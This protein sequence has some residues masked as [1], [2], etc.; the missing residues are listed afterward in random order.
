MN[1]IPEFRAFIST[2]R[3]LSRVALP[4]TALAFAALI[5]G[6]RGASDA[7]TGAT[8][9]TWA[10]TTNW[11]GGTVPGAGDTA[12]FNAASANTTV[13]L[14][15]GVTLSSLVFDTASA[16]AYTIGSGGAGNQTLT[17]GAAGNAI[18]MNS[19]VVN[20]QLLNANLAF[21]TNAITVNNSS[22]TNALTIAGSLTG[23][24]NF[25][26]SGVGTLV[27]TGT[28]APTG[29]LVLNAGRLNV[30]AGTTNFGG[31]FSNLA[32]TA[33]TT[34]IV[35]VSSGA[36]FGLTGNNGGNF[37]NAIG[38]SAVLYN[39]GTFNQSATTVNNAGIYLGNKAS[40]Y[41]YLQN[42][43][44][45]TTT[46]AGR[47][48]IARGEAAAGSV[49][50]LDI[51]GGTVS[52]NPVGNFT[53]VQ[54]LQINGDGNTHATSTSYAGV[55]VVNG[56]LTVGGNAAQTNINTGQNEYTSFNI[57]GTG[58]FTAGNSG[59]DS[60]IGLSVTNIATNTATLSISNGGT[61]ETSYIYNNNALGTGIISIDN[62]TIRS[63]FNNATG[64]IQGTNTKTYIQSGGVTFDTNGFA[65]IAQN[66][67]LAPSGNG[68]TSITLGGTATSYVG[69]PVVQISGGGGTGA[70][71]IANFDPTTG[72]VTGITVTAAGSGYTSAPTITLVGGNGGATGAGAGTATG[73]ASIGAVTGGGLT[74]TGAGTLTLSAANTYTGA[75]TINTG[76]LK[77]ASSGS[78]ASTTFNIAAGA[79]FDV[80]AQSGYSLSGKAITLSLD[81]VNGGSI[82]ASGLVL[83]LG[84]ALTL[85]ITTGTPGASYALYSA[86]STTGSFGSIN[87][88]GNFSGS[89]TQAG[90][91]WTGSS[92]GY[93]FS[94]DQSTGAL[95][96]AAVPEP[97]VVA[98]LSL[99]FAGVLALRRR[100]I[101]QL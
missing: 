36:T 85:N 49:G 92:N 7:W 79:I 51:T 30:A 101:T 15:A 22:T 1:T 21:G 40:S 17:I 29:N 45:A 16:A 90:S 78:L 35:S 18:T 6:A 80:S 5:P 61:L 66:P 64:I 84:G 26:K 46:I 72:T 60:G 67:L 24:A 73:M 77:L 20:D 99:G 70:A 47:L 74:K 12:T 48:W 75:T 56:T 27:L 50:V 23:S 39:S 58:K 97:G 94:L 69:A 14:G 9:A 83:D 10:T 68:V 86:S 44:T 28:N 93:D 52:V 88:S 19:T 76:T 4:V 91:V 34:A 3:G 31:T 53:A 37:A 98:L 57:T 32:N 71:A 25:T 42:S 11:L 33:S 38:A 55:N 41:G 82:N 65:T 63:L 95:T 96:V 89:L 87:L 81:G 8:D 62:G 59:T 2:G 54:R 100:H 43:G 13:D